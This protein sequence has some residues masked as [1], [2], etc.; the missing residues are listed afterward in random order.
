[1]TTYEDLIHTL[2]ANTTMQKVYYNGT[3]RGYYIRPIDGYVLHDNAGDWTDVDSETGKE[4]TIT[5]YYTDT[6]SC[7]AN[8][9]FM[10]NPR[11]F[12][13]VPSDSVPADQIFGIFYR[14]T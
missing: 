6:C 13:A 3:F 2:I 14:V 1:M 5:S 9:D 4:I 8:Y 10:A 11:D 7:G 12:Y